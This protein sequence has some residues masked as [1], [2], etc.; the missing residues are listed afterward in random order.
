M[1]GPPLRSH[2]TGPIASRE[3]F[4]PVFQI[5]H[6]NIC[7]SRAMGEGLDALSPTMDPPM[8]M[9]EM[10]FFEEVGAMA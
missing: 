5:K 6:K 1:W 3:G 4:I 10:S 9:F 8:T 2:W 7:F